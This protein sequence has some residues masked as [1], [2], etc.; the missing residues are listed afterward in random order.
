[1]QGS[2]ADAAEKRGVSALQGDFQRTQRGRKATE[3]SERIARTDFRLTPCPAGVE[4]PIRSRFCLRLYNICVCLL[5]LQSQPGVETRTVTTKLCPPWAHSGLVTAF[6][7]NALRR[8]FC[9]SMRIT[10]TKSE[11]REII[12]AYVQE[13]LSIG[14]G[15]EF[16]DSDGPFVECYEIFPPD[17]ILHA[18]PGDCVQKSKAK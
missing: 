9:L 13:R 14:V 17:E 7:L 16:T 1:V 3:T 15:V 6:Y 11:V 10:F 4:R 8:A 18:K 12:A 5:V 2:R